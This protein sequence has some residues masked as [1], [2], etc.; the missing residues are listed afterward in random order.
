VVCGATGAGLLVATFKLWADTRH[1][2]A[3]DVAL[4][5]VTAFGFIAAV[6]VAEFSCLML[7]YGPEAKSP[8]S[9]LTC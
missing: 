1:H 4:I 2:S 5:V 8:S 6:F 7:A 9:D 3:G